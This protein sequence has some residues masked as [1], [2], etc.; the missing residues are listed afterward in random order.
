MFTSS[1]SY[2]FLLIH[3]FFVLRRQNIEDEEDRDIKDFNCDPLVSILVPFY[4]EEDN[5]VQS[6]NSLLKQSYGNKEIVAINDGSKDKGLEEVIKAFNLTK[7]QTFVERPGSKSKIKNIYYS[8]ELKIR[9]IDKYNG[10]KADSLNCGISLCN[11]EYFVTVDGDSVLKY[12]AIRKTMNVYRRYPNT[13]AVGSSVDLVNGIEIEEGEIKSFDLPKGWIERFQYIEYLKSFIIARAGLEFFKS[14]LIISGAFG[15]FRKQAI[16]SVDCYSTNHFGEDM[17][18][19]MRIQKN[20]K[21]NEVVHF[22]AEPLCYTQVPYDKSSLRRQRVRWQKG[23]IQSLF[24][25]KHILVFTPSKFKLTFLVV[26]YFILTEIILPISFLA[27]NILIIIALILK[28]AIFKQLL[29]IATVSFFLNIFLTLASL[30]LTEYY[31]PKKLSERHLFLLMIITILEGFGFRQLLYSWKIKGLFQILFNKKSSWG[32]IQRK[33]FD[34]KTNTTI[35]K[36]Q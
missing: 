9:V 4:N 3:S 20:K 32:Y 24:T 31:Y 22:L 28:V 23:L 16:V 33:T 8:E 12:S 14:N 34:K 7:S 18:L 21:K 30:F 25:D 17:D 11:G 6:I 2:L 35:K 10:G 19:V 15:C 5:I 26:P 13:I 27:V 1:M 36:N 29:L